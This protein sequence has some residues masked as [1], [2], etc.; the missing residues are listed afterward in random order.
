MVDDPPA[1]SSADPT[2]ADRRRDALV[3]HAGR[4]PSAR[5]TWFAALTLGFTYTLLFVDRRLFVFL[6]EPVSSDL[7]IGALRF[8]LLGGAFIALLSA[9]LGV[10]LARFSDNHNRRDAIAVSVAFWCLMTVLCSRASGFAFLLLARLGVCASQ[11]LV[12]PAAVSLIA[13]TVSA[14]QRPL[15]INVFWSGTYIAPGIAFML[16]GFVASTAMSANGLTLPV[17][18]RFAPWQLTL[19]LLALSSIVALAL[20]RYL[21]EPERAE[22]GRIRA[23][24]SLR[25]VQE[26]LRVH[27]FVYVSLIVGA[28][29]SAVGT[30]AIFAWAPAVFERVYDWQ[31]EDAGLVLGLISIVFGTAGLYVSGNY[32]RQFVVAGQSFV[33]QRL[34]MLSVACAIIPAAITTVAD[35]AVGMWACFAA[36]IFFLAMPTGLALSGIVAVT[37]NRLRA[38][39]VAIYIAVLSVVAI[40]LG[41]AAVSLLANFVFGGAAAIESAL[42]VVIVASGVSSVLLLA[43]GVKEYEHKGR[44]GK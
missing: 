27:W 2:D 41:P 44:N 20:M 5:G 42:G 7:A 26:Y 21:N 14:Q 28:A 24:E 30:F 35:S 31:P 37:P 18:G 1:D 43:L 19:L 36:V 8:G 38:Q 23:T 13:D 16:S 11:A 12:V 25:D 10:L 33:F 15:A 17:S 32:A 29:L 4:A 34:M 6:A 39:I 3:V 22:L 40:G 9:L